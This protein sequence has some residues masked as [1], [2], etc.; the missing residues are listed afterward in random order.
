MGTGDYMRPSQC[1]T[2]TERIKAQ[3]ALI[4]ELV[5][6]LKEAEDFIA[7]LIDFEEVEF[8]TLNKIRTLIAK[9]VKEA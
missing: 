9:A 6:A 1:L 3:Q 2:P 7:T 5:E 8:P 4:D